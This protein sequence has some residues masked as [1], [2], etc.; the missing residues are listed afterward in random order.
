MTTTP[1]PGLS[2]RVSGLK[3]SATIKMGAMAREL[4]AKGENVVSL[5]IGVPG[6]LPPRHVYDAALKAIEA[7]T[8]DYLP[9]RGSKVLTDAFLAALKQRGFTYSEAEVC[10]QVGGKGALFNLF[11]ALLN[12][13]DEVVIPAPYWTS[14]PDMVKLCGGVPVMPYAGADQNYKLTADQLRKAI[15]VRT[16]MVLFNNPSN[17]TGMLYTADEAAAIAQ[18][19]ADNPHVW[20]VSDD[21]YDMLVF[22][23]GAHPSGRAAELLDSQPHLRERFVIVQSVSKTYGMPG[24]RVGMV[25]APKPLIDALLTLTSQSFTH[26]PNVVM[27]AAAAAL[28]GPQDFLQPQRER[29]VKQRDM[30]LAVMQELKLPCP[31]PQGAFYIFPQVGHLFGTKSSGGIAITDDE[32]FCMALLNEAKLATVPGGAFGDSKAIRLSYAGKEA[33]L[34]EGLSRLKKFV[35]GLA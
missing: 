5:S 6:F 31:I 28:S 17:P 7:D 16:K 26:L 14:Y 23:G 18:V 11:F 9:S 19:L 32:S 22:D 12:D 8:G 10:S 24:W 1:T 33:D 25:A 4:A 34:V 20:V 29:L 3:P 21:I 35:N 27:A 13:G 30:A 15:T 2:A